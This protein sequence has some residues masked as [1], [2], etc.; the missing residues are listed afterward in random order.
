[1]PQYNNA[2]KPSGSDD[3]TWHISC[4]PTSHNLSVL[5]F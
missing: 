3:G 4:K 1:M 5:I 2:H